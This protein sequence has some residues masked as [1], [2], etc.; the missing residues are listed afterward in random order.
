MDVMLALATLLYLTALWIFGPQ[1][2]NVVSL[3]MFISFP[4]FYFI[5][6]TV[7]CCFWFCL[8]DYARLSMKIPRLCFRGSILRN[9]TM[10]P[11]P[12]FRLDH[13]FIVELV[14]ST[15]SNRA[16]RFEICISGLASWQD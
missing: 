7:V 8:A 12:K 14:F 1:G 2:I 3:V 10:Q 15:L 6:G 11:L 9:K 4:E 16:V 5:G 13:H